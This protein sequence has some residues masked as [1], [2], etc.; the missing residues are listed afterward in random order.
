MR[1][2]TLYIDILIAVATIVELQWHQMFEQCFDAKFK[3]LSEVFFLKIIFGKKQTQNFPQ[4]DNS[5]IST[6]VY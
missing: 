6:I 5:H 2:S 4:L 1:L 3:P